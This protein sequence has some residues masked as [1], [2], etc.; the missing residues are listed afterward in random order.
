MT[1]AGI[2]SGACVMISTR[3]CGMLNLNCSSASFDLSLAF[4][5]AHERSRTNQRT[6]RTANNLLDHFGDRASTTVVGR[7]SEGISRTR[8]G[9][10]DIDLELR[11]ALGGSGILG[12]RSIAKICRPTISKYDEGRAM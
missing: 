3:W 7:S 11:M 12:R 2:V 5:N 9:V 1:S 8:S 6:C 10:L 4:F